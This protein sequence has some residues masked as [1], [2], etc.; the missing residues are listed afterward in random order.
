MPSAILLQPPS[1]SSLLIIRQVTFSV[2]AAGMYSKSFYIP[3]L[4]LP[5]SIRHVTFSV[6]TAGMYSKSFLQKWNFVVDK[7]QTWALTASFQIFQ[8]T[9][10]SEKFNNS[11]WIIF[12][13]D[14][15]TFVRRLNLIWNFLKYTRHQCSC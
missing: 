12:L 7:L 14:D 8:T 4:F 9:I 2:G 3:H 6:G 13:G 11:A 1:V 10:Q 5:S 15:F